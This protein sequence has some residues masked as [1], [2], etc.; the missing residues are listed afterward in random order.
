L[1]G[2]PSGWLERAE[3]IAA[4]DGLNVNR[5]GVVSVPAVEGRDLGALAAKTAHCSHS[6]F[7]AILE[8]TE[9]Q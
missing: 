3:Q 4:L 2:K 6:V 8:L 5:R 7:H 9:E 1:A